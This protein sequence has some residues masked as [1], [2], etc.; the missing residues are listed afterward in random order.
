MSDSLI[1]R[2][3]FLSRGL[4]AAGGCAFALALGAS[5]GL[6]GGGLLP[7]PPGPADQ[8]L[9]GHQP[10]RGAISGR[11]A[12]AKPLQA[13]PPGDPGLAERGGQDKEDGGNEGVLGMK[14]SK[15]DQQGD[16][17]VYAVASKF[18]DELGW[19]FR[20]QPRRDLGIDAIVEVVEDGVSEG[21]LLALQIKSGKS[22][23]KGETESE[24]VFRFDDDHWSYWS[25]YPLSVFVALHRP[26]NGDVYWQIINKDNVV[27]TGEG[28]KVAIPKSNVI[29]ADKSADI[30]A[31]CGLHNPQQQLQFIVF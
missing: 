8:G 17:G 31:F 30:K 23:F 3:A 24:V 16:S 4:G 13:G 14:V 18:N 6:A 25:Q 20:E 27:S 22:W 29:S 11:P 5:P 19:I 1:T 10:G 12:M 15:N 28:W 26:E 7:A 2:R 21:Q 9:R